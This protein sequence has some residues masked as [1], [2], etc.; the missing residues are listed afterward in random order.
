MQQGQPLTSRKSALVILKKYRLAFGRVPR[1]DRKGMSEKSTLFLDVEEIQ[2]KGSYG[3][4]MFGSPVDITTDQNI[5][6]WVW[7]LRED[8][9][10]G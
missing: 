5:K 4:A 7:G 10:G 2:L 6:D 8:G 3:E 1:Q 9:G